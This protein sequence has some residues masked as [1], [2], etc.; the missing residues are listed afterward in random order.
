SELAVGGGKYG[1]ATG[2]AKDDSGDG[3]YG[4][5]DA[6]SALSDAGSGAEDENPF[7]NPGVSSREDDVYKQRS[8]ASRTECSAAGRDG[9][10]AS[11]W[12]GLTSG[13]DPTSFPTLTGG[14][15]AWNNSK[16][17]RPAQRPTRAD[18]TSAASMLNVE[19]SEVETEGETDDSG[20][21]YD[22]GARRAAPAPVASQSANAA[23]AAAA[24]A[25]AAAA[26][27]AAAADWSA[28]PERGWIKLIER[29][30]KNASAGQPDPHAM[31][32]L[33]RKA[34]FIPASLRKDVWRLLILGRV[35]ATAVGG[36]SSA[37][38]VLDLDVEI[39]STEL[40]LENQ[41][42]V[43]VDVERTRTALEQFK[44]PRVKN[45][46][47]RVLTHFC[48]THGLGYKQG[49]HEVL[50]PFVALSDPELPTSDI[51]LCYGAFVR[52][53]LPY[54]FNKDEE[55][56][57]LQ[58]CFRLFRLLLLYHHP[59]LCRFLDQYQL[60]P[61]LY[62]TPW[63][64]TL[65]S[66]SLDLP[67]LY[68]VWDFYLFWGDPALH[69]FVVLAFVIGNAEV[70][71]KAEEANLPETMCR[72]TDGMR[73]VEELRAL[74]LT[75]KDLMLNTP[76]SFRKILRSA[77][78]G[79]LSQSQMNLVLNT[80]Q[81]SSC[82]PV[83]AE[84]ITS[85]ILHKN[86]HRQ[87]DQDSDE[88]EDFV[89]RD[90]R[91]GGGGI[92][93]KYGNPLKSPT[94]KGGN[95]LASGRSRASPSP[96]RRAER[97]AMRS[98]RGHRQYIILDCR[99]REEFDACRLAPA[100]HLDPELMMSPEK[101]DAK[102]KEFLPLQ[103]AAHFC[104]VGAGDDDIGAVG[105]R[106]NTAPT[107]LSGEA[108]G[109][110]SSSTNKPDSPERGTTGGTMIENAFRADRGGGA[111][112]S[113]F[114]DGGFGRDIN[115]DVG[116]FGGFSRALARGYGQAGAKDGED[117]EI[118]REEDVQVTRLVLML[119][120]Y[121]FP[122]ISHVRGDMAACL[123]ELSAQAL[124]EKDNEHVDDG[125]FHET[126]HGALIGSDSDRV[127]EQLMHQTP[128]KKGEG[129]FAGLSRWS[130]DRVDSR[131]VG[132][133]G[134]AGEKGSS[135]AND[136]AGAT[137]LGQHGVDAAA[138]GSRGRG[139]LGRRDT[140][141]LYVLVKPQD[142]AADGKSS[143]RRLFGGVMDRFD[144]PD[145]VARGG[146]GGGGGGGGRGR[147]ESGASE[148][149][150]N[151]R[152]HWFSPERS[153]AGGKAA[154]DPV[155]ASR[156]AS[157]SVTTGAEER[158]TAVGKAA[159][160]TWAKPS[161]KKAEAPD[162]FSR[163]FGKMLGVKDD[164]LPEGSAA[165]AD[166]KGDRPAA[167][168]RRRSPPGDDARGAG[169]TGTG[170]N[171]GSGE[172][173]PTE[174]SAAAAAADSGA[175]S[176]SASR[177]VADDTPCATAVYS[178][179][180]VSTATADAL[181]VA[182]AVAMP[183][184]D[185]APPARRPSRSGRTVRSAGSRSESDM[186]GVVAGTGEVVSISEWVA[187]EERATGGSVRVFS[188]QRV[189]EGKV[190]K[191]C[192]LAVSRK[193]LTQFD[194]IQDGDRANGGVRGLIAEHR[195]LRHLSR[196]TSRKKHADLIVFHFK[197]RSGSGASSTAASTATAAS[198]AAAAA[199]SS[200]SGS[201]SRRARQGSTSSDGAGQP[202]VLFYFMKDHADCLRMV[203]ENYRKVTQ[204]QSGASTAS[205]SSS[206]AAPSAAA[207]SSR[208]N[209]GAEAPDDPSRR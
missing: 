159:S 25:K 58:I 166:G 22:G 9:L 112:T 158:V 183:V 167:A 44:R 103:G 63:F 70:I 27:A 179:T 155:N 152:P 28:N 203:K 134:T 125:D 193:N 122:F 84:E 126:L 85:Y 42:V 33:L 107:D 19:M 21:E 105:Q 177:A 194:D 113:V 110:R 189:L 204:G 141:D 61:E 162:R 13:R 187:R 175:P 192:R 14:T 98:L 20:C 39:L 206:A 54:A 69:H 182:V 94:H 38:A 178:A 73:S 201:S 120:Q 185:P 67:R 144:K 180:P 164:A 102:L 209:P 208:R 154:A 117:E 207:A 36:G 131:G 157:D 46:L 109:L 147:A 31:R 87:L 149:L 35:E 160:A 150:G 92:A 16:S 50:A 176:G 156:A 48:K 184:A 80:L 53:F 161:G 11:P 32:Q 181:P 30:L 51:S 135:Q 200:S 202:D 111:D 29:Q 104:L 96:Q 66:N 3:F 115:K 163:F 60:Q 169:A 151:G 93:G 137:P 148:P 172:R 56:L 86:P 75:A 65:F 52:R 5:S 12:K 129:L 72:L 4:D 97:A 23:A 81:V 71:L 101:L 40:D 142:Q 78:Y 195:G 68:E 121:N 8:Q 119:L 6:G 199:A 89:P 41:R 190:R 138:A 196:I 174:I 143:K 124:T 146:G 133:N 186:S 191:K 47:A 130:K 128:E 10:L 26:A 108:M 116:F 7:R 76:K 153:R 106:K 173:R 197:S 55:F 88:E 114:P 168:P 15:S 18:G 34:G 205:S 127:R 77:L 24:A 136:R 37:E 17:A 91:N 171:A 49:M 132:A 82:I 90:S 59:R 45:M 64:M 118:G 62:A 95:A 139:G 188:A 198:A 145:T 99:P 74:L 83:S 43:R 79:N 1:M 123:E 140:E 170:S 2:I 57:S 165:A 100:L